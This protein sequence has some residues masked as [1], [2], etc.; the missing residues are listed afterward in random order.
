M[1]TEDK[2]GIGENGV[3][4]IGGEAVAEKPGSAFPASG[5]RARGLR[6]R[7]LRGDA[8]TARS[9]ESLGI[10]ERFATLCNL[11]FVAFLAVLAVPTVAGED[12]HVAVAALVA[13][14]IEAVVLAVCAFARERATLESAKDVGSVVFAALVAWQ[15][16]TAT[17][18]VLPE[19]MFSAPGAV[20]AQI[21][22]DYA[23][24]LTGIGASLMT[25]AQGFVSGTAAALAIGLPLGFHARSARS[26]GKV[27]AFLSAI[28]P[29][30]YIP[31]GIALLPTFH[32]ASVMVIFLA[33]FWPVLTS[34]L[35]GVSGVD[36]R[37]LDAARVLNLGEPKTLF[38]IVLPASLPTIFNGVNIALC[39]S[40]ILLT[41]AEMIGGNVGMGFYVNYY[42][43]FGD[44]TRV[45]AGILVI[46]VVITA[47]SLG[48]KRLQ[49][50]LTRWSS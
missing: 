4:N 38:R 31:Y 36:K 43:S 29:I 42:S 46:G 23:K 18:A 14:A 35:A 25:V 22:E 40:F 47:I 17:F 32:D 6:A 20:F 8:H 26:A 45:L 28:P 48:L 50:Y 24:I 33:T 1:K 12:S 3:E 10:R 44:F 2:G 49:E 5:L 30:V 19:A 39:L 13:G 9:D 15:L 11:L 37:I 21:G 7:T 27:V 34:T 16:A 41:S